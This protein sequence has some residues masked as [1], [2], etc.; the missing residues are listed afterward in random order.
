M[1][2][3][4]ASHLRLLIPILVVFEFFII[5]FSWVVP[6]TANL[7]IQYT[8]VLF[9]FVE[10][11]L[12]LFRAPWLGFGVPL[13]L[14]LCCLCRPLRRSRISQPPLPIS[15]W[16]LLGSRSYSWIW[17]LRWPI[18]CT[19]KQLPQK[20]PPASQPF[21]RCGINQLLWRCLASL[22]LIQRVG[23]LTQKGTLISIISLR[24]TN[25]P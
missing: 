25:S 18:R 9:G 3:F 20:L 5:S 22:V 1:W 15:L 2:K 14:T 17:C 10:L 6:I 16:P 12:S 19:L 8:L 21:L 4:C 24:I 11:V 13:L 7:S 23:S